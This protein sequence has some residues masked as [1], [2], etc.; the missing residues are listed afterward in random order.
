MT[1]VRRFRDSGNATPPNKLRARDPAVTAVYAEHGRLVAV[2]TD[3][4]TEVTVQAWLND[5]LAGRDSL[6]VVDTTTDAK[7]TAGRCQELLAACGLIGPR[8][9][10]GRD[11]TQICV[12]D[13]IQT[14]HNTTE[15]ATSDASGC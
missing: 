10:T 5:T 12:G 13:L 2:D 11:D 15:L 8:I 4:A 6:I 14:R 3:T 9:G 1:A 7:L